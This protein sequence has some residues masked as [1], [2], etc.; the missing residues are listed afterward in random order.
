M[1]YIFYHIKG[2][3]LSWNPFIH[4]PHTIHSIPPPDIVTGWHIQCL[5]YF[6]CTIQA[7][8]KQEK[9][10]PHSW[11]HYT[12]LHSLHPR[13]VS[14]R[15]YHWPE[16]QG[17]F[18]YLLCGAPDTSV[19]KALSADSITWQNVLCANKWNIIIF[20]ILNRPPTDWQKIISWRLAQS[21]EPWLILA[22][23]D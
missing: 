22:C 14:I 9:R 4:F 23:K 3:S 15:L 16:G 12:K 2:A 6:L 19:L 20:S 21:G 11:C 18:P 17:P 8:I 1:N 13:S 5:I 7:L 10:Y